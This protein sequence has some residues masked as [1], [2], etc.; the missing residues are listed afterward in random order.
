MS[1]SNVWTHK[2]TFILAAVGSAVGLGNLWRFPYVVGENGGGAFILVYALT[3][4][5]VGLPILMAE[6]L[7]GRHGRQSPIMSMIALTKSHNTSK[8]WQVIG[9]MGALAALLIL[10]FYSVIAGWS[11]HFGIQQ[12]SGSMQGASHE[13]IATVLDNLL[14][15]PVL[16]LVY[17][18]LFMVASAIIVGLGVH[19]GLE[20]G[21]RIIMPLLLVMLLLVLAY[22]AVYGEMGQAASYLFSFNLSALS[23]QGWIAAMGQAFFSLS[24]GLGAI[25]AYGAYMPARESISKSAATIALADTGVAL[26]AGLAIFALVFAAQLDPASGP[27]LMFISLPIA[28]SAFPAGALFGGVFFILVFFAALSSS[29]SLIEPVAAFLVERFR[30]SRLQAVCAMAATAWLLGILTVLSFNVMAEGTIFHT[31]FKRSAFDSIDFLATNILLPVGG[32]LIALFAGWALS[33]AE[34]ERELGTNARWFLLWQFAVRYVAPTAVLFVFLKGLGFTS[35][36]VWPLVVALGFMASFVA[37]RSL[38]LKA[39]S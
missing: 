25:M 38:W 16:L 31:L 14:A 37:G 24:L 30:L 9:W 22:G 23:L 11:V 18:T 13:A 15:S 10:S 1:Q 36:D 17:H 2:G 33:R 39:D 29:I 26:V 28:F 4:L 21:L 32:V 5:L 6:T 27:G 3:V 20:K 19:R 34:V 8:I 7:I 35:G 12:F